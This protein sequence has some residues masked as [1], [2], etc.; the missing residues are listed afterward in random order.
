MKKILV[1]LT[2]G[3][4]GSKSDHQNIN[5]D[6]VCAYSLIENYQA[7]YGRDVIFDIEQPFQVLSENMTFSHWMQLIAV[8]QKIDTSLY[9]G[10]ILT[11]GSDTLPYTAAMIGYL[12]HSFPIPILLIASNY[13]LT[14]HR[15]NGLTNFRSSVLF[16][17]KSQIKGVFCIYQNPDS[18]VQVHLATRIMEANHYCDRFTSYGSQSFGQMSE[19][20]FR[21]HNVPQNPSI[22]SI[23]SSKATLLAKDIFLENS[24]L[25]IRSYPGLDYR[26][27]DLLST[28]PKAVLHYLYHS[29][30][31]NTL[32]GHHSLP[33]FVKKCNSQGI[34]VYTASYKDVTDR[35]YASS[36][37][38]L[39]SGAI[40]LMNISMEAAYMKL[41]LLYNQKESDPRQLAT[42]NL[43]FEILPKPL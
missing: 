42:T 29:A 19:E 13:A 25:V 27:L 20:G 6:T 9:S 32:P 34:D 16:I 5:I 37:V 28:P 15:S 26:Q 43:Y 3:T 12:F 14:D 30:T 36:E 31:A 17:L 2:G 4:I 38:I 33:E 39:A 22:P 35:Q 7:K 10:I 24:V 23:H 1:I 21:Y 40:P 18:T 11:H 41:L 8:F